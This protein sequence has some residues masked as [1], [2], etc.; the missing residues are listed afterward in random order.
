MI[1]VCRCAVARTL[2]VG[3]AGHVVDGPRLAV[4][5]DAAALAVRR[6]LANGDGLAPREVLVVHLAR[7]AGAAVGLA[8]PALTAAL[9]VRR[10]AVSTVGARLDALRVV[11]VY[12]LA[13]EGGGAALVLLV[14]GHAT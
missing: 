7:V 1:I 9:T 13:F 6:V 4:A 2:T 3:A 8:G 11:L 10:R 5:V 12:V 14:Q